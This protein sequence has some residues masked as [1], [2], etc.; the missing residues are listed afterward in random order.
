MPTFAELHDRTK[1]LVIP[2]CWD[3]AS[4]RLFEA[5]GFPAVA[6]TSAG[7]A[8]SLGYADGEAVDVD[9]LVGAVG[10]ICARVKC[11]VSVDLEAGFAPDAQGV[12]ALA[13][14]IVEAGASAINLEDWDVTSDSPYPLA[15]AAQRIDALKRRF[16]DHLFVNAR[17]DLELHDFGDPQTRLRDTIERI[18][19]FAGEGAD[20]VFV[21]GVT[22]EETIAALAESTA[23][24]LNVLAGAQTPPV[25]RLGELGVAR[26]SVGSGPILRA[27]GET[28]AV[29]RELLD[30]GTFTYA[31]SPNM[32]SYSDVNAL[33]VPRP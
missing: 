15:L 21:P 6:T 27:L 31:Q 1:P 10:R 24:P 9:E 16:G 32:L 2:N 4:A 23:A 28:Q 5:M 25:A 19:A 22:D 33:F 12:V 13:E 20:C 18:H 3:V 29:G 14:R 11:H 7:L 8:W 26:V 30:R 17:T